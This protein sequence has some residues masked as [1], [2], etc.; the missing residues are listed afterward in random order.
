MNAKQNFII[1]K[2]WYFDILKMLEL[3]L[4]KK[5]FSQEKWNGM[6]L[7]DHCILFACNITKIT[8]SSF[9]AM[10]FLARW[11]SS[12]RCFLW[13]FLFLSASCLKSHFLLKSVMLLFH[14]FPITYIPFFFSNTRYCGCL[15]TDEGSKDRLYNWIRPYL[16]LKLCCS[17][18]YFWREGISP[19]LNQDAI[20]YFTVTEMC[21]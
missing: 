10:L 19:K 21:L 3:K 14:C 16:L 7:Q 8:L 18:L 4:N 6:K 20:V 11:L 12:E 13:T 2:D 9:F 17:P 15:S 1:F 5:S